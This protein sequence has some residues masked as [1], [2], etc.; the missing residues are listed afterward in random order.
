MRP[1]PLAHEAPATPRALFARHGWIRCGRG[2]LAGR[3]AARC[4]QARAPEHRGGLELD[5]VRAVVAMVSAG[6]GVS[7]VQR[8]EPGILL[9]HPVRVPPLPHPPQ[10]AFAMV[11]RLGDAE[12]RPLQAVRGLLG[13]VASARP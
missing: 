6:L 12:R 3:L 9:A 11:R 7:I 8:S 2:T 5:A 4:V 10:I 13:E 1:L